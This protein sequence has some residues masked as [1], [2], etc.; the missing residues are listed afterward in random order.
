M[1]KKQIIFTY[2]LI[3]FLML[4]GVAN[5]FMGTTSSTS[6]ILATNA[7]AMPLESIDPTSVKLPEN[8]TSGIVLAA[9]S[10][11]PVNS[12]SYITG[13]PVSTYRDASGELRIPDPSGTEILN[14]HSLYYGHAAYGFGAI[15]NLQPGDTITTDKG[16]FTVKSVRVYALAELTASLRAQIYYYPGV[17]LMTCGSAGNIDSNYRTVVFAN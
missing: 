17:T 3:S 10:S 6:D 8:T 2:L 12:I 7:S 1:E 4:V 11:A 13:T 16:V 14:Y 5:H 9:R 15:K